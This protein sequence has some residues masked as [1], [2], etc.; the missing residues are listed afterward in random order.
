MER[1]A[2]AGDVYQAGTL[3]GN[4]LAVAAGLATLAMLDGEQPCA[5]LPVD[6]AGSVGLFPALAEH[7]EL[8]GQPADAFRM[9]QL[10]WPDGSGALPWEPDF[11]PELAPVQL[12]L[13]DPPVS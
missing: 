13:G 4:P 2:P 8:A 7:H 6:A 12:L 1:N 11:A 10:A 9:V 3:S 5:L